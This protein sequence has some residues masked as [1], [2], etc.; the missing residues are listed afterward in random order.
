MERGLVSAQPSRP[1][2]GAG[3]ACSLPHGVSGQ[4]PVVIPK[5][6]TGA[7]NPLVQAG[8]SRV[9]H[10]TEGSTPDIACGQLANYIDHTLLKPTATDAE[11]REICKQA[12][13]YH[14]AS[15]CVNPCHVAL[16]ARELAGTQVMVC[17]VI[18]FPLG[19][20]TTETKT[21]ETRDACANGAHE[22]DMVINIGKLKAG[23]FHFVCDDIRA[24]VDAAQGRTVKV[25][26]ETS[27]LANDE[28]IAGCILSKAAGA[29]FVKTSTGFGGG[30]ATPEDIALMRKTVGEELGVKASGGVRDC[31]G[32]EKLIAAGA[33][34]L[35]ASASVAIVSGKKGTG[36]Y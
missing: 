26:L 20:T 23:D 22:I 25:I 21:F 11:I 4:G 14:F 18:G 2:P 27:M 8:A 15:V 34:R 10:A 24:V 5:N 7:N 17:T 33:S 13:E 36:S 35:G 12:R 6:G 1:Q 19:S 31:E 9:G 16:A 32:A 30:G 28:K 29:Q 3:T